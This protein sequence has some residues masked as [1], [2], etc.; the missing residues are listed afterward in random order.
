MVLAVNGSPLPQHSFP[1]TRM[2]NKDCIHSANG[3]KMDG[4]GCI[5]RNGS[6]RSLEGIGEGIK[7]E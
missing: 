7:D 6:G 2:A 4:A 3:A 1:V 5:M